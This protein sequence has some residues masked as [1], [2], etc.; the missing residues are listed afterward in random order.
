MIPYCYTMVLYYISSG[1]PTPRRPPACR[2]SAGE[3]GAG[4]LE[5]Q[6]SDNT[7]RQRAM[8][9]ISHDRILHVTI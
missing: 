2:L 8:A 6:Y 3:G 4:K 5:S 1:A 7:T 9:V